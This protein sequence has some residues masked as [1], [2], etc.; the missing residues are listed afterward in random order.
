MKQS[1]TAQVYEFR[2]KKDGQYDRVAESVCV[3]QLTRSPAESS[4]PTL[5]RRIDRKEKQQGLN[6]L[7]VCVCVILQYL[8]PDVY[9]RSSQ[10]YKDKIA[11]NKVRREWVFR[12]KGSE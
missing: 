8:I 11:K 7:P 1:E 2:G 10:N 9:L 6:C 4:V 12:G 3:F 5:I